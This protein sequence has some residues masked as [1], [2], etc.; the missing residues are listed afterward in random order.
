MATRFSRDTL[1]I[2]PSRN[3]AIPGIAMQPPMGSN[4]PRAHHKCGSVKISKTGMT[5][6]SNFPR[7]TENVWAPDVVIGPDGK[8]YYYYCSCQNGCSI[9]G[10][11]SDTPIGPWTS[12]MPNNGPIIAPGFLDPI[13]PLDPHVFKDD[14]GS[15]YIYFCTW[16]TYAG[17]GVGW[18]K[19]NADMKSFSEKGIIP[20]T[21]LPGVFEAPFMLKRDD[22]YYLMYSAGS[23][24]D[25]SYQVRYATSNGPHGSFTYGSNNPITQSTG[26]GTIDAPGHHSVFQDGDDYYIAYHRHDNPHST[27]G[28]VRQVCIDKLEFDGESIR[29]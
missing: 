7:E 23:T 12:L 8:Y 20:N 1:Q 16:A 6:S 18:A 10:Y 28:L 27:G 3:L 17:H 26:D 4:L 5:I 21:E 24:H 25:G 19:M 15:Y 29:R 11:V 13:I 14:D 9:Y 22:V 2:R